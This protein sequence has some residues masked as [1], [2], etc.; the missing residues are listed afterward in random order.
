MIIAGA[1]VTRP[2]KY[3]GV[4]SR[5]SQ[6]LRTSR[7]QRKEHLA[8]RRWAIH[9]VQRCRFPK[10]AHPQLGIE[11]STGPR[12]IVWFITIKAISTTFS[13]SPGTPPQK[14]NGSRE[15]LLLPDRSL[16]VD[17][18][19][20]TEIGRCLETQ[21]AVLRKNSRRDCLKLVVMMQAAETRASN[22]VMSG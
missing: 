12:A 10:R 6:R 4:E 7:C 22:D 20:G 13:S 9:P 18:S 17:A 5:E 3:G 15:R 14:T 8:C 21:G 1:C 16:S 11:A 19:I 2:Q